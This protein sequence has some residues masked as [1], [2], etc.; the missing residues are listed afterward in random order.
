VDA[1]PTWDDLFRSAAERLGGRQEARWLIEEVSGERLGRAVGI[2]AEKARRRLDEMVARRLSGEPIQYVLGS[3]SFRLLDLMVDRR[4]LIPRPETEQVVEVALG[5][6]DRRCQERGR[7][8]SVAVDLGTGSGAIALSLARERTKVD[9]WAVD[10]STDALA[11]ATANLAG[12]AG[13]AAT[14]VRMVAGDWYRA[15]PDGLRGGVD[16]VVSNPPYVSTAEMSGL[17]PQVS[18]W[19]PVAALEAGPD[20][21]EAIAAV[22]GEAPAWLC[23]GGVAV[24]EIAPHQADAALELAARAGFAE[25]EIADDLAGRPRTLV[26]RSARS[27]RSPWGPS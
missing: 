12:L 7:A 20:G 14:R 24:V 26:A 13:F 6:L 21:T 23:P 2:P 8:P 1:A 22:V 11:V 3:W 4:V 16:L 19:E 27:A 9:V 5:E 25:A 15:L 17:D 18:A 10:S